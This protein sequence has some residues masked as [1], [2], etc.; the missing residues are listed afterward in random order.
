MPR[1]SGR[2]V[3][4]SLAFNGSTSLINVTANSVFN[5]NVFTY[6]A[7][8]FPTG[9][10]IRTIKGNATTNGPQ[11]RINGSNQLELVKQTVTLIGTSTSIVPNNKFSYVACTYDVSGNYVFYINGLLAG[12]GTNLQ[13]FVFGNI[14]I[15]SQSSGTESFKGKISSF[16]MYSTAFTS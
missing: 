8:V 5:T 16:Q 7:I 12:S 15:G 10:G 4:G 9:S 3:G 11:F 13:T 1:V 2:N 14:Q 6:T